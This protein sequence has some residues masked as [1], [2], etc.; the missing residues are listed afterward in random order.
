V[1][2][3]KPL[4]IHF[5]N[6]VTLITAMPQPY[7]LVLDNELIRLKMLLSS[8]VTKVNKIIY[9]STFFRD[10]KYLNYRKRAE[11]TAYKGC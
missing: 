7:Y 10:F 11:F 1:F 9:R 8:Y 3:A 5:L 2:E 4:S 6:L